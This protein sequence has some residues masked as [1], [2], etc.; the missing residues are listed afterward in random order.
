MRSA[1]TAEAGA[2][3]SRFQP[4]PYQTMDSFAILFVAKFYA[5][6]SN[7]LGC[8]AISF[9]AINLE[10]LNILCECSPMLHREADVRTMVTAPHPIV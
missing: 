7:D 9:G 8:L 6:Y 5:S 10:F 3:E 1:K 2:T 4:S